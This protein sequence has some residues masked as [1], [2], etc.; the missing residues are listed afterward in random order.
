MSTSERSIS[1]KL[2]EWAA[3]HR[4]PLTVGLFGFV[5]VLALLATA[6][7]IGIVQSPRDERALPDRLV[8]RRPHLVKSLVPSPRPTIG[9][10]SPQPSDS[11]GPSPTEAPVGS[12]LAEGW[13][14]VGKLWL[15]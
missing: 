10:P 12:M 2:S 7:A 14:E 11:A 4:R 1:S 3:A 9:S 5:G 8:R 6:P 15:R 13:V